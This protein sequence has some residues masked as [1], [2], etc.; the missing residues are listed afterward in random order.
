MRN[1]NVYE[2]PAPDQHPSVTPPPTN[3]GPYVEPM[4]KLVTDEIP[5]AGTK[6]VYAEPMPR[7]TTDAYVPKS[8]QPAR[9]VPPP[10]S[11]VA[12]N[13]DITP[14]FAKPR[15]MLERVNAAIESDEVDID[16]DE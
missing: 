1:R 4:P 14:P 7:L 15:T 2:E 11:E 13:T 12:V 5:P 10:L 8:E 6:G 16:T 9:D 3:T